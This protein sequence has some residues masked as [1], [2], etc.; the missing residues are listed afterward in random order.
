MAEDFRAGRK[1]EPEEFSVTLGDQL[2]RGETCNEVYAEWSPGLDPCPLRGMVP[3][4][5]EGYTK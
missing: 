5:R 1:G 4:A 3:K 2:A